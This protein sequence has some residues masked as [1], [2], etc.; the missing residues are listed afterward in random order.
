MG[1]AFVVLVAAELIA[2]SE[3]LGYMINNAR[4]DFRTDQ[5]FVGIIAIGVLGFLLNKGLLK[6]ERRLLHWKVD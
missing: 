2:S 3:G 5:I 6:A 1:M 4:F